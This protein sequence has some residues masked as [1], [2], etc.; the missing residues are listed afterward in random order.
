MLPD[1]MLAQIELL[2]RFDP[3]TLA[4]ELTDRDDEEIAAAF[5][6]EGGSIREDEAA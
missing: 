5:E 1:E 6:D 3:D 2:E 4:N